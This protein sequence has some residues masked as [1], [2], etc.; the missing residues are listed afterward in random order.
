[1]SH[2]LLH[3]EQ[4]YVVSACLAGVNCRYDGQATPVAAVLELLRQGRALPVCPEQ[5]GGLGTPRPCCELQGDRVLDTQGHDVTEAFERGAAEALRLARLFGAS[6]AILKSRSPSCGCGQVYDGT[7]SGTLVPG[8]GLFAALLQGQ[9]FE[10]LT[11]QD[12]EQTP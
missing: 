6:L 1:M 8:N 2:P 12:L 11:E 10:I 3:N 5:L 4:R 7:F 9:E